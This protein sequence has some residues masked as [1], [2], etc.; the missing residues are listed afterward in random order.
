VRRLAGHGVI[1]EPQTAR[2]A[3]ELFSVLDDP[4]L[5]VFTDDKGPLSEEALAERLAR[6]ESRRSPD[7]LEQWLNWVIRT[8]DGDVV[9]YVQ[10]TVRPGNEAEIAYVLGRSYWR[11]GYAT[12]AC[13]LM[14]AELRAAYGVR[15]AAATLDPQNTAS[16][17]LLRK[18]GFRLFAESPETNEASYE[19]T[20]SP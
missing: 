4:A 12:A 10:A 7:G 3:A 15:R 11:Q 13:R 14:L 19:L 5:Y 20:L 16:L 9:G 8:A 18:L 1:L 6:L 17:A 2:D